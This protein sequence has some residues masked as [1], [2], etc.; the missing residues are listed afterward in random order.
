MS[1]LL[2]QKDSPWEGAVRSPTVIWSPLIKD[3]GRVSNQ[4]IHVSDWLHTFSDVAGFKVPEGLEIDGTSQWEALSNKDH[5]PRKAILNNIDDIAGYAS[6]TEYGWKYIDGTTSIGLYDGYLGQQPISNKINETDYLNRVLN[7]EVGKYIKLN[8]SD[9]LKIRK[10]ATTVCKENQKKI[11]CHPLE[12]PCLFDIIADPCEQQ[13]LAQD[14]PKI[15]Q[16]LEIKV[17]KYRTKA[18]KPRNKP[19]DPLAAPELNEFSWTWWREN[20]KFFD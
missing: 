6:Y 13:N 12:H 2:Q 18:E 17:Q 7:S 10:A 4:W 20:S 15:L 3:K 11:P 8:T 1:F 16:N 14:Y 19:S 9:I 5:F